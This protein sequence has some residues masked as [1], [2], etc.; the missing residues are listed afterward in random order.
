VP[1]PRIAVLCAIAG[2]GGAELSLLE[3]VARLR[4]SYEFH[5]IIPAQG[6]F[7]ESAQAAG[8]KAWILPWPEAIT[9]TGETA[10]RAGPT[11]LLGAAVA[12]R[13]LTH[14]LADLLAEIQ[15]TVFVTNAIKAHIVGALTCRPHDVP[16]IWYM[17]DGLENR[18]LS[19]KLMALLSPRCDTAVCISGYVA[20]QFRQYVSQSVAAHIVYNIVDFNRF[21]PG[22]QPPD[23]LPKNPSDVWFGVV[24]AITPL[25]GQDI[26]LRAAEK[27]LHDLSNAAFVIA[28]NNVYCTEVGL[29]Y[30]D[31]LHRRANEFL[32]DRVR[33]LGFRNDIPCVLSRLDVLVQPNRGP[34][35]LGRSLL[36]AM[37]CGVPVIAVD[38]WGPAEVVQHGRTGLLFPPLDDE[39]LASHMV[40]LGLNEP[41]RKSMGMFAHNWIRNNLASSKLTAQFDSVLSGL[42]ASQEFA[43]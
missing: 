9:R 25:K 29:D 1:S 13:S 6:P 32:G 2:V 35:G 33:F 24:G 38:K 5:L 28:G 11:L 40:A 41:L 21:H 37:A 4:D 16:L 26:F 3:L 15:P 30:A 17:R 39:K 14:D 12:L 22:A 8:A 18:S 43:L 19:R 7:V 34:E 36:E 42:V 27:V 31:L 10:M 20:S 23:D